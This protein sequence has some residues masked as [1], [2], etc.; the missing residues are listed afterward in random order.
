M[1]NIK[2][3]LQKYFEGDTS[4]AEESILK[5]YF[6]QENLPDDLKQYQT[7]FVCFEQAQ[8]ETLSD[9]NFE[10][11]FKKQVSFKKHHGLVYHI[12]MWSS[13]AA[14]SIVIALGSIYYA[15]RQSNYMIV[16]GK[17]INDPEKAMMMAAEKLNLVTG[18]FN[19]SVS[20]VQQIGHVGKQLSVMEIF[21][22]HDAVSDT[23]NDNNANKH[24]EN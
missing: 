11:R 9:A 12:A 5:N 3:L 22:K 6:L 18:K 16:N 23:V 21:S 17:R 7:M 15:E 19:N 13:A 1:N 20:H 2:E 4:L 14:A 10:E 24:N 8:T